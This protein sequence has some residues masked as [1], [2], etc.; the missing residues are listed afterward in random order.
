MRIKETVNR[1]KLEVVCKNKDCRKGDIVIDGMQSGRKYKQ[2]PD[3]KTK[4][5]MSGTLNCN[6]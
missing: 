2:R 6:Q 4:E 1:E 5:S 3:S